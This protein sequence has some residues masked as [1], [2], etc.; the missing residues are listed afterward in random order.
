MNFYESET[1][2]D[3]SRSIENSLRKVSVP[4]FFI[5]SRERNSPTGMTMHLCCILHS[6]YVHKIVFNSFL[7][8][9]LKNNCFLIDIQNTSYV[10]LFLLLAII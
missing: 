6:K 1:V 7:F 3:E 9:N 4:L 8:S 10:F 5:I 2:H